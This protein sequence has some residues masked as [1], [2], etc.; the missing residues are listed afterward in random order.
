M[1]AHSLETSLRKPLNK[2]QSHELFGVYRRVRVA[3]YAKSPGWLAVKSVS[4][5]QVGAGP[6]WVLLQ[7][8][9]PEQMREVA[10]RLAAV[11]DRYASACGLK[12][13]GDEGEA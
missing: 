6:D 10:R 3:I 2:A 7:S 8:G 1:M 5:K 12:M 11:L 13:P 9:P 4:T